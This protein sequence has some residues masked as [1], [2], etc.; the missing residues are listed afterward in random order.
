MDVDEIKEGKHE[1]EESEVEELIKCNHPPN[2]I[3]DQDEAEMDD[4]EDCV[5]IDPY[6]LN[7]E[8]LSISTSTTISSTLTETTIREFLD[9]DEQIEKDSTPNPMVNDLSNPE[10]LVMSPNSIMNNSCFETLFGRSNAELSS[11]EN[12]YKQF[13]LLP[14]NQIIELN[15]INSW[16]L[17]FD[18]SR[19]EHG[20]NV[21]CLLIDPCNNQTYLVVQLEFGCTDT[22][23][24]YETLIQGLRKAINMNVKYIEVFGGSQKVIK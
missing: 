14:C 12:S 8:E 24:E 10:K 19:N 4:I 13:E 21:G 5:E 23:A 7:K 1:D 22:E 20:A 9:K 6:L 17:Y 11:F 18:I 15:Y 3:P 2:F 16:T